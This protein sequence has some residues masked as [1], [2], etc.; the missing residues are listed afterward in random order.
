MLQ[1]LYQS[2]SAMSIAW[3]KQRF[4]YWRLHKLAAIN[5]ESWMGE[6]HLNQHH[7]VEELNLNINDRECSLING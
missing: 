5:D 6:K 4:T 3:N 1:L 7:F 2:G